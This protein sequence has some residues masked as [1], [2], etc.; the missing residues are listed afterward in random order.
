MD[1]L[2]KDFYETFSDTL[3]DEMDKLYSNDVINSFIRFRE[4]NKDKEIGLQ[5]LRNPLLKSSLE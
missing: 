3:L 2:S 1:P 4:D 5:K